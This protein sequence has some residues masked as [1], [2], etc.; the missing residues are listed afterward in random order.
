MRYFFDIHL[1]G[2]CHLDD[3]GEEFT[4]AE[5]ARQYVLS[6]GRTLIEEGLPQGRR[7]MAQ[8]VIEISDREGLSDLIPM[9]EVLKARK[10]AIEAKNSRRD[11]IY[12]RSFVWN[13]HRV[14]PGWRA[15]CCV[16]LACGLVGYFLA[17]P[18]HR[19]MDKMQP[20]LHEM[21][22]AQS[23]PA[24]DEPRPAVV[25]RREETRVPVN[26]VIINPGAGDGREND[27]PK[28]AA[29]ATRGSDTQHVRR[30]ASDDYEEMG[31]SSHQPTAYRSYKDLRNFALNR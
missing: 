12:L 5:E 2:K 22:A 13:A 20:S 9:T 27:Q 7:T 31:P 24:E 6:C 10:R 21:E 15:S 28:D 19:A 11:P 29:Q 30:S 1:D 14:G 17:S 18:S 25:T 23:L 8:C 16:A 4:S 26:H 3:H